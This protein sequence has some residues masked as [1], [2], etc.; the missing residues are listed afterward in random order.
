MCTMSLFHDVLFE[1]C[2]AKVID[3]FERLT[4]LCSP[5]FYPIFRSLAAQTS[6]LLYLHIV[7]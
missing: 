7:I 2:N 4:I 5:V 3:E 1:W 6:F